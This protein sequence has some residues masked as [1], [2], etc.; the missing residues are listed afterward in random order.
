MKFLL[1]LA[2]VFGLFSAVSWSQ[3]VEVTYTATLSGAAEDT[4]NTSPGTGTASVTIDLD[5]NM[6]RVESSFSGLEGD[7][8]VAHIHCCTAQAL[9]GA[10]GVATPTPTFP[11]FPAGVKAGSY[12][13]TFDLLQATTYSTNFLNNNGGTPAGARDALLAGLAAGKA[14]LNIHS[15]QYGSGEI[16]GFL[17]PEPTGLGVLVTCIGAATCIARRRRA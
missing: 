8:S 16:R 14:Y 5:T 10:V 2:V 12:N 3:A 13:E 7:V 1:Q 15:T 9:T 17:V 6:M 4:P 11:G